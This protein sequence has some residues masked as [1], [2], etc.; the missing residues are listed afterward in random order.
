M[1]NV[2]CGAACVAEEGAC[3]C[4]FKVKWL[5]EEQ[6]AQVKQGREF[7]TPVG[8]RLGLDKLCFA[9]RGCPEH[10][11]VVLWK[12][13]LQEK[14]LKKQR[15]KQQSGDG[16][17]L[18]P[19][20]SGELS[21][22]QVTPEVSGM[23]QGGRQQRQTSS[24][25]G[26]KR[27]RQE[28]QH[29]QEASS[30]PPASSLEKGRESQE[31]QQ[32]QQQTEAVAN[33]VL[34]GNQQ[35]QAAAG[36]VLMLGNSR[37]DSAIAVPA[38][39]AGGKPAAAAH[40]PA[41]ATSV[42]KAAAP[43]VRASNVGLYLGADKASVGLYLGGE[44]A[45]SKPASSKPAS[46]RPASGKPA[47]KRAKTSQEQLPQRAPDAVRAMPLQLPT[48]MRVGKDGAPGVDPAK[49]QEYA[50]KAAA[51]SKP[52]PKPASLAIPAGAGPMAAAVTHTS[53][54]LHGQLPAPAKAAA[55]SKAVF[56]PGSSATP[57]AAELPPPAP[58]ALPLPAG[59]RVG[60]D[61]APGVDAAKMHEYAARAAASSKA[62]SRPHS[63]ATVAGIAAAAAATE[64]AVPVTGALAL[65]P[66]VRVGNGGFLGVDAA[67]LND[68][69][70]AA[71]PATGALPLPPGMRVGKDGVPGV[72][73][74]KM[75]EYAVKAAASS[76]APDKPSSTCAAGVVSA[77]AAGGA[78]AAAGATGAAGG[79]GK[80]VLDPARA[81]F[82]GAVSTAAAAA[83]GGGVG[84][85]SGGLR[86]GAAA[87]G[88]N[89]PALG[90]EPGK[91]AALRAAAAAAVAA[92]ASVVGSL[93]AKLPPAKGQAT[94]DVGVQQQQQGG[95]QQAHAAPAVTA[96]AAGAVDTK[97]PP[98][99]AGVAA[100]AIPFMVD[101]PAAAAATL[102]APLDPHAPG[103]PLGLNQAQRQGV[104][105][106]PS[107]TWL[108]PGPL[109]LPEGWF[110]LQQTKA[111]GKQV[112]M[113]LSPEGCRFTSPQQVQN[114]LK[115]H[116]HK[117]AAAAAAGAI[118]A[119]Y[120]AGGIKDNPVSTAAVKQE[121][122]LAAGAPEQPKH[123]QQHQ[124]GQQAGGS[125]KAGQP[126]GSGAVAGTAATT[127]AAGGAP[128]GPPGIS[129]FREVK[130]TNSMKVSL[131]VRMAHAFEKGELEMSP[132]ERKDLFECA[133]KA[134]L[135]Q[136]VDP[137]AATGCLAA[138]AV[139]LEV[140][141][142]A[143]WGDAELAKRMGKVQ[144]PAASAAGAPPAA[145][146]NRD[147]T[148]VATAGGGGNRA[149]VAGGG[150]D[151]EAI[152]GGG[153]DRAA[154]AGAG[155]SGSAATMEVA[156]GAAD[157]VIMVDVEPEEQ[158]EGKRM[159]KESG[160]PVAQ[161]A[162]APQPTAAAAEVPAAAVAAPGD[163]ADRGI[164]PGT[165]ALVSA[166]QS[167]QLAPEQLRA[168]QGVLT[169]WAGLSLDFKKSYAQELMQ[170]HK[171]VTEAFEK[172]QALPLRQQQ[173]LTAQQPPLRPDLSPAARAAWQKLQ[174]ASPAWCA[175]LQQQVGEVGQLLSLE[176]LSM[177]Q[178]EEHLG[179]EFS[180]QATRAVKFMVENQGG[181]TQG[182]GGA[183]VGQQSG[184]VAAAGPA[185]GL[186]GSAADQL[187]L[188]AAVNQGLTAVLRQQQQHGVVQLNP[189]QQ[190][191]LQQLAGA[192]EAT[193]QRIK[194]IQEIMV[195]QQNQQQQQQGA[196][197]ATAL[198]PPAGAV[199]GEATGKAG[200]P[201]APTAAAAAPQH[202][203]ATGKA[204]AP[205]AAAPLDAVEGPA[206]AKVADVAPVRQRPA[207]IQLQTIALHMLNATGRVLVKQIGPQSSWAK[208]N[209]GTLRNGRPSG[210]GRTG[211][212][213]KRPRSGGGGAGAGGV[214][215]GGAAVGTLGQHVPPPLQQQ[216]QPGGPV[217][218][219]PMA[220]ARGPAAGAGGGGGSG[221][222]FGG[223]GGDVG[224]RAALPPGNV[225][226]QGLANGDGPVRG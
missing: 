196:V 186:G 57:A 20:P 32:Q 110:G 48:G 143:A 105:Q 12:Q 7:R 31:Q 97:P 3:K 203:E 152:A 216:Q 204:G 45:S 177:V 86:L 130:F 141:Q 51:S 200:A 56:F 50:E 176:V 122:G 78:T 226:Q 75:N 181:N 136:G 222:G 74:A 120:E 128:A 113:Y 43:P 139:L 4:T 69:A 25:Q 21:S 164:Q 101:G 137:E 162:K 5:L 54:Y 18:G 49:I 19:Q 38:V 202:R 13:Q 178:M 61:G 53:S 44:P 98:G 144:P 23:E 85:G 154:V 62:P 123:P 221:A 190:V 52:P 89:A 2:G 220:P 147:R 205:A 173:L 210:G 80:E 182:T 161:A 121:V 148:A 172:A 134:P 17:L 16:H 9:G 93:Q 37:Q 99:A 183:G 213:V 218:L 217:S 8:D 96:A 138:M 114:R 215:G 87:G 223:G 118:V 209:G 34:Q 77:T 6:P 153:G 124:Q 160:A 28:Q 199:A 10:P 111:N 39:T 156:S 72:D 169:D 84:A 79:A 112:M 71:V 119:V 165:A 63:A 59:M 155:D 88:W 192:S 30:Q 65:P 104:R 195:Q 219:P 206:I 132:E 73:A 170:L 133:Q 14:A 151:R 126:A 36:H 188:Q 102:L 150:G 167:Q 179:K 33:P 116:A 201:A 166:M 26:R 22:V 108:L 47:A 94:A 168:I 158:G 187:A 24:G 41:P 149:A 42:D 107:G 125:R 224:G 207:D 189:Q 140:P 175:Q 129:D 83:A 225:Q 180:E 103:W 81:G 58:N 70:A 55:S 60:K 117:E 185:G 64:A 46:G 214:A 163:V 1:Y 174:Q 67:Q 92:S 68:Y 145:A 131:L 29:Q 146:G 109:N 191:F 106:F 142:W 76:M 211:P 193:A 82:D 208:A 100:R 197:T 159:K 35:N 15:Q 27:G 157:D 66:G 90:M 198:Q 184:T 91:K 11:T 135:P 171:H 115:A 127:A 95:N 212:Q 40:A 194:Q